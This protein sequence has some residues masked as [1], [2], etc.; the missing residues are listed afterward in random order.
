M[1]HYLS[2][3]RINQLK[4]TL[5]RAIPYGLDDPQLLTLDGSTDPDRDQA[6]LAKY[7][8][9]MYYAEKGWERDY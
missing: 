3:E 2:P 4:E 8:L 5:K 6:T 1:A 7:I 9:D